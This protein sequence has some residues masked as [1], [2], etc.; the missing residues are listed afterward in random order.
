VDMLQEQ[1]RFQAVDQLGVE[2]R[3]T[4]VPKHHEIINND[5]TSKVQ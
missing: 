1:V 4:T 2:L 5:M 3:W